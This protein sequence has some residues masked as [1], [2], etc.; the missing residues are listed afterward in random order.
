MQ[1]VFFVYARIFA[2]VK[3]KVTTFDLRDNANATRKRVISNFLYHNYLNEQV[4][5]LMNQ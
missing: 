5:I 1:N 2:N 3:C 4:L